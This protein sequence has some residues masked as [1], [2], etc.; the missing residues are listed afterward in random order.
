MCPVCGYQ[1]GYLFR[2]K[3]T[4]ISGKR[5]VQHY[6]ENCEQIKLGLKKKRSPTSM[7]QRKEQV[8]KIN[9]KRKQKAIHGYAATKNRRNGIHKAYEE[10]E[11]ED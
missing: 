2:S 9:K 10:L 8:F 5:K 3:R 4:L 1:K 7:R 11:N 6:C